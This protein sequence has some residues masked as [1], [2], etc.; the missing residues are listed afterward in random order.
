M[1]A[2]HAKRESP[3]T[4]L[5]VQAVLAC[6][7][8]WAANGFEDVSGWFVTTSWAFYGVTTAA[9]F[10]QRAKEKRGEIAAP[11]YKTPLFPLPAIVFLAVTAV[12]IWSDFTNSTPFTGGVFTALAQVHVQV[13]R[14]MAGV[15][16]AATGFP[17]YWLWK[18][19]H[20]RA[21]A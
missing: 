16:I 3:A 12:I 6:V 14:A 15:L 10:V 1:A 19:R 4:A 17:V 18:G 2:L 11:S 13:P 8:L 5:W 20:R 21:G 9:L 7:W